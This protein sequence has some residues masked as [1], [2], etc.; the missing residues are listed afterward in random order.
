MIEEKAL[1][2][3]VDG[4]QIRVKAFGAASC[5]RC[6]AGQ[7]CGGGVL[8]RL[9]KR[10]DAEV[11][12]AGN[13]DGLRIG[14]TV[15]IGLAESALLRASLWVY[16][17]P[18][19]TMFLLAAVAQTVLGAGDGGVAAAGLTGLAAGFWLTRIYAQTVP[20]AEFR[21]QLL[22]RPSRVEI[23]ACTQTPT[24]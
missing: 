15:V 16:L 4:E 11:M 21:P 24:R 18:V 19:L 8:A 6:A 23:E 22:R 17:L 2:S 3:S 7:G 20:L 12:V 5:P 9:L 13:L 1:V 10:R 14:D